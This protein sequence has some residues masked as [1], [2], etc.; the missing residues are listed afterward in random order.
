MYKKITIASLMFVTSSIQPA[1]LS[2]EVSACKQKKPQLL[3]HFDINKTIIA[4]DAVQN[5][6]VEE[7]V[8][9]V[10]AEFTFAQWDGT[11]EQSYYAYVTDQLALENSE[12]PRASEEFKR[13]RSEQLK[14]F[15]A[16]VK[17][18]PK[19]FARYEQD[20]NQM[21]KILSSGEMVIF[22][23][24]YKTVAWLNK[25]YPK[26]YALYLRTFGKDLPE[27]VPMIEKNTGIKF[28]GRGDIQ[29]SNLALTVPNKSL[30]DFLAEPGPKNYAIRDDYA[31][32]KS[33]GFQSAGGKPFPI[34]RTND[35]VIALFFDDNANDP[36]KPIIRPF[37]PDGQLLDTEILLKSGNI[38]A[39]NTKE[40]IVDEDY[41]INK[42]KALLPGQESVV[43]YVS[44]T[45]SCSADCQ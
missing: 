9:G 13:K 37:G 12:F 43:A 23:S 34:D 6:N 14:G 5:K 21:L 44:Q 27:V 29:E 30:F 11:R 3:L 28:A 32:W 38:V 41:F 22:P 24:F 19:M 40:A 15:S 42:I 31:Y 7:T 35:N 16:F 20:K 1:S 25:Q 17:Q 4:M 10:L 45:D 18:Y 33:Q 39:V 2:N 26:N 36:D 8:N